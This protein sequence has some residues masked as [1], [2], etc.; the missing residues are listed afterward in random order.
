MRWR[1]ALGITIG[2]AV[3]G[4]GLDIGCVGDDGDGGGDPTG[5]DEAGIAEG[6]GLTP[7]TGVEG[8]PRPV[9]AGAAFFSATPS[10]ILVRRGA[11]VD[12]AVE[13]TRGNLGGDVTV[14]VTGLPAGITSTI[15]PIAAGAT[16]ATLK[17]TATAT[18][19]MGVIPIALGAPGVTTLDLSLAVAG[20][21]G[22]NDESFDNDGFIVDTSVP[23][24]V[25]HAV[26]LQADG[27]VVAVGAADST[28][29]SSPWVVKRYGK[30]GEPDLAFGTA[31]AAVLPATGSARAIAIDPTTGRIVV[32]GGSEATER[33]TLV[34]LNVNGT[35]DETF[36]AAGKMVVSTV[37]HPQGS[38]AMAVLVLADSS[39]MVA[40]WRGPTGSHTGIVDKYSPVGIRVTG[41]AFESYATPELAELNGLVALS[42]NRYLAGGT[43]LFASPDRQIAVRLLADGKTD[44]AFGTSGVATYADGCRGS[45][46]GLT[47]SGD[48][49]LVGDDQTAPSI[50]C[51][52]RIAAS[53]AGAML[54]AKT[55][56]VGSNGAFWGATGAGSRTYAAGHGGGS[57]DRMA[58]LEARTANGDLDPA[59]G[60]GG[61]V[62]LEDPS[63]PD[64][65][66]IQFRA[67]IATPDGRLV[68]AGQRFQ[69][70]GAPQAAFL[71]RMWQ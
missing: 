24:A 67:V 45:A 55:T 40:G 15:A 61:T 71:A 65:Y 22:S 5:G 43:D 25:F 44:P 23:N 41:P 50:M 13:L 62:S 9:D 32:A 57:Q 64:T 70:A 34:R 17:L 46:V 42:G 60:V 49:V 38:R 53:A 14:A 37:D 51:T 8:G 21:P 35:P 58:L 48:A 2:A 12:V 63:V 11:S 16:A 69:P 52:T 27:K 1:S 31:A 56:S 33:L 54:Y 29:A 28:M 6:G 47:P 68:V 36:G 4:L 3:V 66:R 7:E 59:F 19:P 26:A 20:A 39:V 10:T 18:A 30:A